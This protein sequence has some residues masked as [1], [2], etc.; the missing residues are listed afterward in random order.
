MEDNNSV[1]STPPI[2]NSPSMDTKK[3]KDAEAKKPP[4]SVKEF[5]VWADQNMRHRRRMEDAHYTEDGFNGD[6]TQGFFAVYDGTNFILSK[7]NNL[8]S[9][10]KG[11]SDLCFSEF[12]LGTIFWQLEFISH[13]FLKVL[14]E[15]LKKAGNDVVKTP[16]IYFFIPSFKNITDRVVEKVLD[17]LKTTFAETDNKMKDGTYHTH[18]LTYLSHSQYDTLSKCL[19]TDTLQHCP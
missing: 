18:L 19:F 2:D 11:S 8:R 9:W 13:T 16:G 17:I 14:A 5:G 10:R 6:P 3:E 15:Q 7:T 1:P 12:S 4:S